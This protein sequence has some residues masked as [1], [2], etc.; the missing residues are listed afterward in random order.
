MKRE[1]SPVFGG[2]GILRLTYPGRK[3][4]E[5]AAA[6]RLQ[7]SRRI[8]LAHQSHDAFVTSVR[9]RL[10]RL[11]K[12]VFVCERA[13]KEAGYAVI[14]DGVFFL[15][16]GKAV[17][18][19]VENSDK[20]RT[21]FLNLAERWKDVPS[22]SAVLYVATHEPLLR[23]LQGYL[24]QCGVK[25]PSLGLISFNAL[26]ANEPKVWRPSGEADWFKTGGSA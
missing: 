22:I 5:A 9:L 13:I 17:A 11:W 1:N 16:G 23:T 25:R 7:Q 8:S 15:Q 6:K 2:T 3:V 12:G 14:P 24:S 21:R 20:G 10:E 19:E 26:M 4:A 18:I